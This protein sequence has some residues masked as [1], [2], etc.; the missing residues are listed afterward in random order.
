MCRSAYQP[1]KDSK[2]LCTASFKDARWARLHVAVCLQQQG[3]SF[4]CRPVQESEKCRQ[5]GLTLTCVLTRAGQEAT[6]A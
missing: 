4:L 2:I 3:Q 5:V 1:G 6:Q